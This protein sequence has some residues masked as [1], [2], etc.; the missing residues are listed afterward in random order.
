MV[1]DLPS[2]SKLVFMGHLSFEGAT[3]VTIGIKDEGVQMVGAFGEVFAPFESLATSKPTKD[4]SGAIRIAM[5]DL[6]A[7]LH[8]PAHLDR[9]ALFAMLEERIA[10]LCPA[11]KGHDESTTE[12]GLPIEQ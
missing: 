12:R 10:S 11:T 2:F 9:F 1:E 8:I 7:V 5:G 4:S 3:E 6:H